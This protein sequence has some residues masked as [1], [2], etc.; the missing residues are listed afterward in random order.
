MFLLVEYVER[1]TEYGILLICS[2]FCEYRNLEYVRIRVI[3]RVN[4]AE[5]AVRIHMACATG[6][7][8]YLFN[9]YSRV[10]LVS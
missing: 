7:R 5:Y 4:Q 10:V 8:E 6:I 9:T 2:L 1:R 3:C